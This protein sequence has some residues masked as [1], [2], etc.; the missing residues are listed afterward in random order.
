MCVSLCVCVVP[1]RGWYILVWMCSRFICFNINCC[2]KHK[3]SLFSVTTVTAQLM[4]SWRCCSKCSKNRVL[5]L[6]D[7]VKVRQ[8]DQ[9]VCADCEQPV[10]LGVFLLLESCL[11]CWSVLVYTGV[12]LLSSSSSSSMG[13]KLRCIF[14]SVS[15]AGHRK[16]GQVWVTLSDNRTGT[17]LLVS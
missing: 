15:W 17:W 8:W 1:S 13:K 9:G 16:A 6:E 5:I 4:T 3:T 11:I 7:P 12:Y 2:S 14:W 10:F